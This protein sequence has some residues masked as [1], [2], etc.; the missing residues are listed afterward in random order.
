MPARPK[1]YLPFKLLGLGPDA[2]L[3]PSLSLAIHSRMYAGQFW[4]LMPSVSQPARN[5]TASRSTSLRSFKFRTRLWLFDSSRKTL[6]SSAKASG[7]IRPI[8]LRTTSSPSADLS[9]FSTKLLASMA[10]A[11]VVQYSNQSYATDKKCF[12]YSG[13]YENT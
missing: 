10:V 1:S 8:N 6:C 12:R 7:S 13:N 3:L 2:G 5:L 11:T 9:I 4:S